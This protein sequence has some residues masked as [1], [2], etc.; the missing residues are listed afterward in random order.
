MIKADKNVISGLF[1]P[2]FSQGAQRAK[3]RH[4]VGAM[5]SSQPGRGWSQQGFYRQAMTMISRLKI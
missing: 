5:A 4:V 2:K 3:Q 1:F